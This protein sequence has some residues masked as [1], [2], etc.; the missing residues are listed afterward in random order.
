MILLLAVFS[1][2]V[3]A[4]IRD[5]LINQFDASLAS[6]ARALAASAEYDGEKYEFEVDVQK[7]PEFQRLDRPAYYQ[8]WQQ[9]GTSVGR[10]PSLGT[11]NLSRL[12]GP[13]GEPVFHILQTKTGRPARAAGLKFMPRADS[14]NP[15]PQALSLVV[16]RDASGLHGQLR[17]LQ[18]ILLAASGVTVLL[19]VLTAGFV[20]RRGLRP[21][22]SIAAEIAGIREGDLA[23]RIGSPS[24]PAEILPIKNRL[25]EL[26][27]R[28]EEAFK[29]ERRF[30]ADVAHE[31]R[32]PLAG[33]RS[34]IEVSLSRVRD[35]NEYQASLSDCLA[36]SKNMERMVDN[37]LTLARVDA[38]QMTFRRTRIQPAD[39]VNCC[40]GSFSERASE[41][42]LV[43]ENR[44]PTEMA[45]ESDP[46]GLSMVLLNVLD[47]ALEYTNVGGRIWINGSQTDECVEITVSN[48][49]CTLTNEE[50]IRV[51][52]RFWRGDSARTETGAHSGLGLAL[53]NRL[54][55]A[56]RGFTSVEIQAGGVFTIRLALPSTK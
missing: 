24:V 44:I 51:F 5:A 4:V 47:N 17:L 23:S 41:R 7:M 43:F 29:R 11:D 49:G 54:I 52:D 28:L 30:T 8:L 50:A 34:T 27:S 15:S 38:H 20:V 19:S 42:G 10:S 48:T 31:L 56:L 45:C 14:D 32:T 16:V 36:I 9:D 2:I 3:Y 26:L 55:R 21:L 22:N 6:T 12:E 33:I 13:L 35:A 37:L 39:L 1:L 46:D 53:A 40:W 25:N 18:L